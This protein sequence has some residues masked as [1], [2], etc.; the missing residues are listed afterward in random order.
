M[1]AYEILVEYKIEKPAGLVSQGLKKAGAAALGAL[2]ARHAASALRGSADIGDRANAYE[3][4]FQKYLST[5][6]KDTVDIEYADLND[7][8]KQNTL[9]SPKLPVDGYVATGDLENIFMDIA[10]LSAKGADASSASAEQPAAKTINQPAN[11]TPAADATKSAAE[12][13]AEPSEKPAMTSSSVSQTLQDINDYLD[14][15]GKYTPAMR[16]L[17]KNIWMKTGGTKIEIRKK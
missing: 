6:G 1:K 10:K 12:P 2:G 9:P 13:A 16:G 11:T 15:G 3:K 14:N 8:I 5:N 7:F 4:E 17:I